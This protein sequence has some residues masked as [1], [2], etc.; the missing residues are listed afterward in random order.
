MRTRL[1]IRFTAVLL[2]LLGLSSVAAAD[3]WDGYD[4]R[5]RTRIYGGV[6][7]GFGGDIE[8]HGYDVGDMGKTIGGQTGVDVL[9]ARYF[10]LGGEVRVGGFDVG[11]FDDRS[12]LIDLD[13]K[14]RLRLPLRHTPIELYLTT[15]IGLTIPRLSDIRGQGTDENIGWNV[16][17]GGGANFW[18]THNFAINVEP[19]YLIH[20]FGLD[21]TDGNGNVTVKQF[22]ILIN[23]VWAF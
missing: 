18:I 16:G 7:L 12:R 20:K 23:A 17:F 8:V 13:F 11:H 22:S 4:R 15:P 14:P 9:V 5:D 1:G 6:W 3:D 19:I 10:S 21:G 2:T